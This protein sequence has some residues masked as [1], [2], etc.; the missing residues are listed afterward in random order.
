MC[1]VLTLLAILA[2]VPAAVASARATLVPRIGPSEPP[3]ALEISRDGRWMVTARRTGLVEVWNVA[4]GLRVSSAALQASAMALSPD[5]GTIAVG[6]ERITTPARPE[7]LA[8][9]DRATMQCKRDI[10]LDAKPTFMRFSPDGRM[11]AVVTGGTIFLW[12]TESGERLRAITVHVES[13]FGVNLAFSPDGSA[14]AVNSRSQINDGLVEIWNA[15]TGDLES[16][17]EASP[18]NRSAAFSPD[19]QAL[20]IGGAGPDSA[21]ASVEIWDVARHAKTQTIPIRMKGLDFKT[22][23]ISIVSLAFSPD[24][25]SLVAAD[26]MARFHVCDLHRGKVV[27][28][29]GRSGSGDLN[30]LANAGSFSVSAGS[31]GTITV[32][33]AADGRRV[34]GI[35]G[36]TSP[37]AAIAFSNDGERLFEAGFLQSQSP[38]LRTGQILGWNMRTGQLEERAVCDASYLTYVAPGADGTGAAVVSGM[39]NSDGLP[40]GG[41]ECGVWVADGRT[42][43]ARRIAAVT[44]PWEPGKL[45]QSR[46]GRLVAVASVRS[47]P[48]IRSVN[49]EPAPPRVGQV[50][51]WSAATGRAVRTIALADATCADMRFSPDDRELWAVV[52][53]ERAPSDTA[54][55]VWDVASGAIIRRV[56]ISNYSAGATTAV[57]PNGR[58]LLVNETLRDTRTD[59]VLGRL[60]QPYGGITDAVF[61]ADSKRI[62]AYLWRTVVVWDRATC[63]E[64]FR[65]DMNSAGLDRTLDLSPDGRRMAIL[66]AS[67][68]TEIWD[69]DGQRLCATLFAFGDSASRPGWLSYTPDGYYAGDARG[70]AAATWDSGSGPEASPA[71]TRGYRRPDL[72][73][74]ALG[75]G[76]GGSAAANPPAAATRAPSADRAESRASRQVPTHAAANASSGPLPTA[77]H[78]TPTERLRDDVWGYYDGPVWADVIAG[79]D[80]NTQG[81]G[82]RTALIRF[83][84]EGKIADVRNMLARGA[85]LNVGDHYGQTALMI[86]SENGD[87]AMIRLLLSAGADLRDASGHSLAAE[88]GHGQVLGRALLDALGRASAATG[89]PN[90][91][92]FQ[93]AYLLLQLGADTNVT[94]G[95]GQTALQIALSWLTTGPLLDAL[96]AHGADVNHQD[97]EGKT[98]LEAAC[99]QGNPM[100]VARLLARGAD[101]NLAD[102]DGNTPLALAAMADTRSVRLLLARGADPNARTAPAANRAIPLQ[103]AVWNRN[104]E[105]TKLLLDAGADVNAASSGYTPLSFA[106]KNNDGTLVR[107]LLAHGARADITEPD[108]GLLQVAAQSDPSGEFGIA[109]LLTAAGAK[110]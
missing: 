12:N 1:S 14:I 36:N 59:Q 67:G 109:A 35:S 18:N 54:F 33:R 42:G 45:A 70:S 23:P 100:L 31:D 79:A 61:S 78:R 38:P 73:A 5:G 8:I 72:V 37:V 47:Q 95:R 92:A 10:A 110:R 16:S 104:V 106:V 87:D 9:Y 2:T 50:E 26:E 44:T 94:D 107:L 89:P 98:V 21:D 3:E 91:A 99:K 76:S 57:S 75:A 25:S 97:F 43:T 41:Q 81:L 63:R 88:R 65:V 62:A 85:D 69:V 27:R 22:A 82:G 53:P 17:I 64:L 83:A 6:G 55:E 86:A 108:G 103:Y 96:I 49:G 32:F 84:G 46:D 90:S 19:G 11:L 56:S 66:D 101:P 13:V 28:E 29:F 74:A 102:R 51:V 34:C 15:A 71:Q 52:M 4:T 77:A 30:G 80:P 60:T 39:G 24:G 48:P 7:F 40:P 20:A 58:Y 93:D 68:A 105:S